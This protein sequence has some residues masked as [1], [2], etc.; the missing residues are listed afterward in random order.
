M[1]GTV[2]HQALYLEK[3]MQPPRF[4][5]RQGQGVKTDKLESSEVSL[6]MA[7]AA[8]RSRQWLAAQII[9]VYRNCY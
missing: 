1:L 8:E 7:G 5:K 6:G 4:L 3:E 9:P 2:K